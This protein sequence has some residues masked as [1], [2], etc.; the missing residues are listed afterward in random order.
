MKNLNVVKNETVSC[1]DVDWTLV[2]ACLP[3]TPNAI[4]MLDPRTNK[5]VY[6]LRYEEHIELLEQ[7]KGRGRYIIVWSAAGHAWAE[8]IVKQ[9]GIEHLVDQVMTKPMVMVD[10]KPIDDW[11]TRCF[12][13]KTTK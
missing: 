1:F 5:N 6:F 12:L 3:T 11:A 13:P 4:E 9:L 7:M 2:E 10:D 8:A